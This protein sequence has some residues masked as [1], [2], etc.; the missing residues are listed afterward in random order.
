[1]NYN[2]ILFYLVEKNL[3][4]PERIVVFGHF[5]KTNF[6]VAIKINDRPLKNQQEIECARFFKKKSRKC[7]VKSIYYQ[8]KMPLHG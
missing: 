4:W 1:M 2:K 8:N 7:V 5:S 6:A 3:L